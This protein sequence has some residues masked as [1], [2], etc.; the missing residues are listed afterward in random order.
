MSKLSGWAGR[1]IRSF[2]TL[3]F[4]CVFY[5]ICKGP[6]LFCFVLIVP[7]MLGFPFHLNSVM[8]MGKAWWVSFP[9]E[10]SI[11]AWSSLLQESDVLLQCWAW[12]TFTCLLS[13][14]FMSFIIWGGGNHLPL[15]L[16]S[17]AMVRLTLHLPPPPTRFNQLEY[18]TPSGYSVWLKNENLNQHSLMRLGLR[19]FAK[20]VG[21]EA[22]SFCRSH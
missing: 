14:P 18:S 2:S 1:S 12:V 4:Y 10:E 19:I 16:I 13:I 7:E 15:S 11:V 22:L 5:S 6:S 20:T 9:R 3:K 21:N 8:S 17:C